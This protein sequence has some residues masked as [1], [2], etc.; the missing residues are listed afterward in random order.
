M[1]TSGSCIV[2]A[3]VATTVIILSAARSRLECVLVLVCCSPLRQRVVVVKRFDV[4]DE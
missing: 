3:S 2:A 4:D 1:L